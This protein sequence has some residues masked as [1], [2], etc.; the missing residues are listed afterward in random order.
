MQKQFFTVTEASTKF[1]VAYSEILYVFKEG[2]YCDII[3]EHGTYNIRSS[4]EELIEDAPENT[5]VKCH[6]SYAVNPS[7]MTG[8]NKERAIINQHS[9]P[10]SRPYRKKLN[11]IFLSAA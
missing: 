1:K 5:L 9:I 7:L 2:H 4:I 8:I 6:R 10:V 11:T 3:T